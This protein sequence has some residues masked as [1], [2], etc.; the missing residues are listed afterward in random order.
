ML[1]THLTH[2]QL[3]GALGRAGHGSKILIADGNYPFSTGSNKASERV[4]LNLA[5]GV[6]TV[7]EVLKHLL[8]AV[9][10]EAAEVMMPSEGPEPP[11]FREFR[12]LLGSDIVLEPL[13]RF[14]FYEAAR[15]GDLALIIAS[16]DQRLYANL[17]LTVGVV[18]PT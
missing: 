7:T 8:T 14:T 4:F 2:P 5:P 6:L 9:P 12:E 13:E 11:I 17:L 15:G 18:A 10:V 3:L 1:K 16:G